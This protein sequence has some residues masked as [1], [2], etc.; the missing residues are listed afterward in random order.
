MGWIVYILKC[1][2]E[3]LYTGITTDMAARLAMHESGAGAKYTRG[4]GPFKILYT[5][6]HPD[7]GSATRRETEIKSLSRQDKLKLAEKHAL[8]FPITAAAAHI[9]KTSDPV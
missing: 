7:R 2:D 3:T 1:A 6:S 4:R 5:E 9:A 8:S